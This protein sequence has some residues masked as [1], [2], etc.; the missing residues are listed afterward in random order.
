MILIHL[1]P[2]DYESQLYNYRKGKHDKALKVP[3]KALNYTIQ[4]W[5]MINSVIGSFL[6]SDRLICTVTL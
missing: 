4:T 1:W 6:H 3:I 2:T 5:I